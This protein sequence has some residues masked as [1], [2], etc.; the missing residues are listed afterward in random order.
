MNY[1]IAV[2]LN[3]QGT[4]SN[5]H[6]TLTNNAISLL[7]L[8][9]SLKDGF[10]NARKKGIFEWAALTPAMLPLLRIH[11]PYLR[12]LGQALP[13]LTFLFQ[14]RIEMNLV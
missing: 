7:I 4:T 13:E 9:Q 2:R 8:F 3:V 1:V 11:V 6:E 5:S 12:L 10:T 14:C